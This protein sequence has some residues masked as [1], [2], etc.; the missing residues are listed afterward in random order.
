LYQLGA[1]RNRARRVAISSRIFVGN[2][3]Y[4]TS[5]QDLEAVFSKVGP[6]ADVVLPVD[7]ATDRPRGFAFVEFSEPDLVSK[8]IEQ[9]DGVELGGRQL[10]VS[11]AR[12][13]APRPSFG[14][15]GWHDRGGSVESDRADSRPG[16]SPDRPPKSSRPKGSRRGVRGRKRGF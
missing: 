14:G 2:L 16:W 12:E 1:R 13:R 9:L 6:V 8:A 3:S 11:E 15:G 10:R 4:E 5:Q 7:R